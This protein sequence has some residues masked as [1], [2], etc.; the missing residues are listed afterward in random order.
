LEDQAIETRLVKGTQPVA[1]QP[2]FLWGLLLAFLL[3]R[4]ST[5]QV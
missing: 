4:R 1:C 2:V 3:V 5:F